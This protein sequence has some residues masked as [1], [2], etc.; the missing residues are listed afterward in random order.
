MS[1]FGDIVIT[2]ASRS[3]DDAYV[4]IYIEY[5]VT[6]EGRLLVGHARTLWGTIAVRARNVWRLLP[7]YSGDHELFVP[8]SEDEDCG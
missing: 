7:G 1:G 2:C 3:D 6:Y 5:G 8:E 4:A